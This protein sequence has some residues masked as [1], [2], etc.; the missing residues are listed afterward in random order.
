MAGLP[1]RRADVPGCAVATGEQQQ[2]HPRFPQGQGGG[3]GVLGARLGPGWLVD[4]AMRQP[5][6]GGKPLPHLPGHR[7]QL[8]RRGQLAQGQEGLAGPLPGLGGGTA[9]QRLGHHAVAALETD[10]TADAGDGVDDE[11]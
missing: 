10:G 11:P 6:L 9:C 4:D 7:Q 5:Q 3:P 1:H 8:E 2:I